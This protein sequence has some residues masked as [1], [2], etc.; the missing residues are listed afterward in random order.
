MFSENRAFY[1][2]MRK[3]YG[4]ARQAT[5]DNKIWCISMACWINK[6]KVIHSEYV[7]II[8]FQRQESL[9]ERSSVLRCFSCLATGMG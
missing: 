7:I 6:A 8:A 1:E 5:D 2:I 9:Q 3:T 4:T